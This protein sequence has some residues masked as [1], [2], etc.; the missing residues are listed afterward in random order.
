MGK[1][2]QITD[3]LRSVYKARALDVFTARFGKI[4]DPGGMIQMNFVTRWANRVRRKELRKA[5]K[6]HQGAQEAARRRRQLAAGK[7]QR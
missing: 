5:V 7:L 1:K 2:K 6:P 4:R 3:E